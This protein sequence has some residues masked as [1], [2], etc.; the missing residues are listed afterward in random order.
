MNECLVCFT[1]FIEGNPLPMY[2][3]V[4]VELPRLDR[5]SLGALE[6]DLNRRFHEQYGGG[7]KFLGPVFTSITKLDPIG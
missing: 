3:H 5:D 2:N 1:M 4:V 7:S 6:A